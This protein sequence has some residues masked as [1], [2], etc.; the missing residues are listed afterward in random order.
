M[1]R[2]VALKRNW[3]RKIRFIHF[4]RTLQQKKIRNLQFRL[5]IKQLKHSKTGFQKCEQN[6]VYQFLYIYC[7]YAETVNGISL[8]N[9]ILYSARSRLCINW[10]VN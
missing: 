7:N 8:R 6:V 2:E 1:F 5:E 10:V 9:K 3:I 4:F